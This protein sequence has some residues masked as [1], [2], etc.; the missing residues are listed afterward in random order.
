M[1]ADELPDSQAG[2]GRQ[3]RGCGGD[4]ADQTLRPPNWTPSAPAQADSHHPPLGL[5][6]LRASRATMRAVVTTLPPTE[7]AQIA[8]RMPVRRAGIQSSPSSR[9][10]AHLPKCSKCSLWCPTIASRV[11]DARWI[12]MPGMPATDPH[13]RD[14]TPESAVF[15]ARDSMVPRANSCSGMVSGMRPHRWGN[16][17]RAA[18]RSSPSSSSAIC[19]PSVASDCEPIT[20]HP[21]A[22]V[23]VAWASGWRRVA[24]STATP[25]VATGRRATTR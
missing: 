16:R 22:A 1:C 17:S 12:S 20:N 4:H 5:G 18:D 8:P 23:A 14:A 3:G 19:S 24:A 15:S 7:G 2:P 25:R 10:A 21:A 11:F 6:W 9:R 13:H